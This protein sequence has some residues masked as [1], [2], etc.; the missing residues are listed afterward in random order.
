M[1]KIFKENKTT[2]L[3]NDRPPEIGIRFSSVMPNRPT[4]Y[5]HHT[6]QNYNIIAAK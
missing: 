4:Q 2:G 6:V 1:A 5:V 3:Y